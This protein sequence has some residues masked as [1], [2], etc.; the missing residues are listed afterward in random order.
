M[1]RIAMNTFAHAPVAPPDRHAALRPRWLALAII[2]LGTPLLAQ[3]LLVPTSGAASDAA[4]EA[5]SEELYTFGARLVWDAGCTVWG[6]VL[7]IDMRLQEGP[8]QTAQEMFLLLQGDRTAWDCLRKMPG[9]WMSAVN[10]DLPG[11]ATGDGSRTQRFTLQKRIDVDHAPADQTSRSKWWGP[12]WGQTFRIDGRMDRWRGTI[13][14]TR[15]PGER[16]TLERP[17]LRGFF[18]YRWSGLVE[19]RLVVGQFFPRL[20]QGMVTWSEGPFDGLNRAVGVHRMQ[21]GVRGT[22]VVGGAWARRGLAAEWGAGPSKWAAGLS[23]ASRPVKVGLA[24]PLETP[25]SAPESSAA[26]DSGQILSWYADQAVTSV[27]A[28]MKSRRNVAE[29]F[30]DR[31]RSVATM[32]GRLKWGLGARVWA[33]P[34]WRAG[35]VVGLRAAWV[36]QNLS[37]RLGV[38]AFPGGVK[39]AGSLVL[40]LGRGADLFARMERL[41]PADPALMLQWD[42]GSVPE[43]TPDSG[44]EQGWMQPGWSGRWGVEWHGATSGWAQWRWSKPV[45]DASDIDEW[46]DGSSGGYG[47]FKLARQPWELQARVGT[48]RDKRP[49]GWLRGKARHEMEQGYVEGLASIAWGEDMA[50]APGWMFGI[51]WTVKMSGLRLRLEGYSGGGNPDAPPKYVPGFGATVGRALYGHDVLAAA[52]IRYRPER[53]RSVFD[54]AWRYSGNAPRHAVRLQYTVKLASKADR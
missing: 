7:A 52:S 11:G 20:G 16:F 49:P 26:L 5:A 24:D 2:L 27:E 31:R 38:A 50:E 40:S 54:I 35:L 34:D 41:D 3:D 30:V 28:F 22:V 13:K 8:I 18:E 9:G 4:S 32:A 36:S 42:G 44:L 21:G 46:M 17:I 6:Q 10:A 23:L 14:W 51:R 45:A 43:G 39:G 15:R 29:I 33:V 48:S 19:G 12:R 47:R 25:S 37:A 53:A 1:G